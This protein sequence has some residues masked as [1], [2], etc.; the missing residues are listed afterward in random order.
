MM[1]RLEVSG[2]AALLAQLQ[3]LHVQLAAAMAA[4][5]AGG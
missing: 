3:R 2:T 5:L 1:M 4:A